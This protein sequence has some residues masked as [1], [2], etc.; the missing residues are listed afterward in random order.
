MRID[1]R[2]Y[3]VQEI[4][5]EA[6]NIFVHSAPLSRDVWENYFL[7]LSKTYAAILSEGLTVIS[8]PSMAK[9]LLK[10]IATMMG[11]WGGAEGVEQ[12]LLGEIRRLTN[13]VI[14]SGNGW[15]T[16]PYEQVLAQQIV[17]EDDIDVAEGAIV[18]F[19]CVSAVQRGPKSREKLMILLGGLKAAWGASSS[20][21]DVTAFVASLSTSTPVVSSGVSRPASS[22]PH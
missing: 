21:L 9:L 7:V 10:R 18:F 6:G 19:T 20:S 1:R 16:M 14:P 13:V 11:I 22:V 12:G 15:Q 3:L 4:P 8:G 5:T 17:D 2:L